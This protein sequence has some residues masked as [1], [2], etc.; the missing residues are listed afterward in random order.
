[1]RAANYIRD[2]NQKNKQSVSPA[3]VLRCRAVIAAERR[4]AKL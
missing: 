1:M 4:D 3:W 2:S